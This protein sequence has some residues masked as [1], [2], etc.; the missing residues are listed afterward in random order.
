MHL[1]E[2]RHLICI[3][4]TEFKK[5]IWHKTLSN[6][7]DKGW[8]TMIKANSVP[9]IRGKDL[10]SWVFIWIDMEKTNQPNLKPFKS[11]SVKYRTTMLPQRTNQWSVTQFHE[12][13]K[14]YHSLLSSW[15][16]TEIK[17]KEIIRTLSVGEGHPQ[18][19]SRR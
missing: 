6:G 15:V 18:S 7:N 13:G 17:K 3:L 8:L 4:V 14:A 19:T 11:L 1:A 5:G 9:W 10:S 12:C 16:F 2:T